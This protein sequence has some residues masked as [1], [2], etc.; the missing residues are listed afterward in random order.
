MTSR[1]S[2]YTTDLLYPS[3]FII[4]QSPLFMLWAAASSGAP[5]HLG[6]E[7]FNYC[8]LGCGDGLTL[9]VLASEYPTARFVG[10][11][12][13]RDHLE[14]AMA[15]A[16]RAGLGNVAFLESSF[17]DLSNADLPPM[18]FIAAHGLY[19]WID[20]EAR[21][22]LH[23]FVQSKLKP[24][25]LFCLQYSCLPG[26][27]VHDPLFHYLKGFAERVPGDSMQ[28]FAAGRDVLQQLR[29]HA[30]FFRAMPQAGDLIDSFGRNSLE[31]LAHDVLNRNRH[32]LYCHEAHETL[33]SLGLSFMGSGDLK[34][35]HP[36]LLLTR[37]AYAA[38][39]EVTRHGD[40]HLRLAT[41]DLMLNT[42][43]R[44]DVFRKP[45]PERDAEPETAAGCSGRRGIES[46]YLKR[47]VGGD[48]IEMR[49]RASENIAVDLAS[50]LHSAVLDAVGG[51]SAPVRDVLKS[52]ELDKF[53]RA[54]VETAI[55][56]LIMMR[57]M[58]MLIMPARELEYRSDR[59]YRLASAL[60]SILLDET[61]HVRDAIAFASPVLGS[62]L[63]IP[64]AARLRMA[65]WL[66]RDPAAI[67]ATLER[68]DRGHLGSRG[69]A[70][71]SFEQFRSGL[72]LDV[73]KFV[74][75]S[76]PE[77]IR[78]GLLEED[79]PR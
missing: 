60:N 43:S 12:I 35:N 25:G 51:G 46:L 31:Q 44:T 77:L 59:R 73:P 8:D 55:S 10:V 63:M 38:F 78:L 66:G 13:N 62:A 39:E 19:S 65:A 72:E 42:S 79:G 17:G 41:Q 53:D 11:D 22:A 32:S 37:A 49:R 14:R 68:S 30:A 33:A 45:D 27:A 70:L 67:W 29:P 58:N 47:T 9:N 56:Q 40:R 57:F 21:A 7:P 36:E 28:R 52:V 54:A 18:D 64:A 6:S 4:N 74:A 1:A 61:I 20:E 16:G 76:V 5:R 15:L 69:S 3:A 75:N 34:L 26:T 23:A 2:A 24:G 71:T 50:P 48:S